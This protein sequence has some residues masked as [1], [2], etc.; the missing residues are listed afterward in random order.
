MG[1]SAI[2]W[3]EATLLS[4]LEETKSVVQKIILKNQ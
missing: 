3:P 2:E 4:W 1:P